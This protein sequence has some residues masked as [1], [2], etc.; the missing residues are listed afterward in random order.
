MTDTWFEMTPNQNRNHK[1]IHSFYENLRKNYHALHS[2]LWNVND[3][4]PREIGER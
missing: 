1:A 4:V 2:I 3:D